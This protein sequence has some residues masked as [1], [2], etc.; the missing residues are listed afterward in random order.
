[1][2]TLVAVLAL[3]FALPAQ[4]A[5][6]DPLEAALARAGDNAPELRKAL[7]DAPATHRAALA[8]LV[9]HMPERDPEV[10]KA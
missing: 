5:A 2:R 10:M 9:M 1:M 7:A 6:L 8:F 3:S 4:D